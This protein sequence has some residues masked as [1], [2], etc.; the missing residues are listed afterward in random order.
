MLSQQN[1]W[2][3]AKV[4]KPEE[5]IARMGNE[6]RFQINL[7]EKAYKGRVTAFELNCN[8]YRK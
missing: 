1:A 3:L 4:A 6:K 2:A 8:T 7:G 5:Y